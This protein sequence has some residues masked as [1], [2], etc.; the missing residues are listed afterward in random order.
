MYLNKNVQSKQWSLQY[1]TL[2][3]NMLLKISWLD[4]YF[5]AT[6][7]KLHI[8]HQCLLP[9]PSCTIFMPPQANSTFPIS[10]SYLCLPG[11][12]I[13]MPPQSNST[14]PISASYLCLA[15]LYSCHHKQTP[16]SPPVPLTSARLYY[17]IILYM[18]VW[19]RGPRWAVCLWCHLLV[20]RLCLRTFW[21]V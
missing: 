13:F 8:P 1:L 2:P 6:T 16:H 21:N 10:A 7:S 9:L 3:E 14:F 11:C 20:L 4:N 15:V 5:H 17:I 19:V 18:R 12:T